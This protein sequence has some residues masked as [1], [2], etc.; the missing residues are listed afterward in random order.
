M[1]DG[2]GQEDL[3]KESGKDL[4]GEFAGACLALLCEI[5]RARVRAGEQVFE[6]GIE[7]R[8]QEEF[9]RENDEDLCAGSCWRTLN[10]EA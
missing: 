10:A 9:C 2:C 1:L 5:V 6:G 3:C 7:R 8:G 4:Y